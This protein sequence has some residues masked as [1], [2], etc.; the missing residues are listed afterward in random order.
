VERGRSIPKEVTT[1]GE[2]V[3]IRRKWLSS[4]ATQLRLV[5]Y[6]IALSLCTT[7]A[8]FAF[9]V[10]AAL[11]FQKTVPADSWLSIWQR[12][13]ALSFL[14]LAQHGY[15]HQVGSREYLIAWLPVFPMAIRVAHLFIPNWHAAAV[16]LSNVCCAGALTYLFL[17]VRMEYEVELAQ[18]AVLFCAIFPTAYFLHFAYSEAIFLLLT[19]AAFYH[20]RRGQWLICGVFGMLA[21]GTRVPGIA[22]VPSLALEYLQQRNFRWRAIRWDVAFLALVPFGVVGY[23]CI[24]YRCFGD[25]LHF[26]PAQKQLWSA[27][28]RWPLPSV[29][30]N[31]YGLNHSSADARLIQYGGR[32]A[33]FAMTT[34]AVIAAPFLL[35]PCYALYL[36]LSW[37]LVFFNNFP[38]SSP[39]YILSIFPI[40]IL[41][42][43]VSARD[44][45]RDSIAFLS[46]LFYAICAMHFARG[47]WGF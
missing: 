10:C 20:A 22:I 45:V 17:L 11:A 2:P 36:A 44:W 13:D 27:F 8:T 35:R 21:T 32:L 26:L 16:V 29:V 39:R 19:I 31:W 34:A 25:P 43:R 1:E 4:L 9:G 24:N 5:R 3:S 28:L 42:G 47:W 46:A 37:I 38:I 6:P 14:D 7:A 40:F 33:A 12:W 30:G 15:P 23:L 18:R 41:L